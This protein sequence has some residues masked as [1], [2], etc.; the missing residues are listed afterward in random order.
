MIA[1]LALPFVSHA[2]IVID[3]GPGEEV[4]GG[5]IVDRDSQS[6]AGLITQQEDMTV[7]SV[8]GWLVS[9]FDVDYTIGIHSDAGGGPGP[10]IFSD[11]FVATGLGFGGGL[12]T[13]QGVFEQEWTLPAGNY[14]VVFSTNDYYGV[15]LP[16]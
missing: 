7:S 13:W 12:P 1:F 5:I 16:N 6:V 2:E 14:W 9:F 11:T 15:A 10:V 8:E 4:F 3:T